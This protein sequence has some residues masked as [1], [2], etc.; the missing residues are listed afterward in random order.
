MNSAKAPPPDY[1]E[2]FFFCSGSPRWKFLPIIIMW[3]KTSCINVLYFSAKNQENQALID[4]GETNANS[5]NMVSLCPCS[6][7]LITTYC[8]YIM[9]NAFR[10][11]AAQSRWIQHTGA[12]MMSHTWHHNICRE[13]RTEGVSWPPINLNTDGRVCS[14]HGYS[15]QATGYHK[16]KR[17]GYIAHKTVNSNWILMWEKR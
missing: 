8:C 17:G 16:E 9:N 7:S 13:I 6:G 2:V 4:L 3:T 15:V 5:I 12:L 1:Y 14:C 11:L 10:T